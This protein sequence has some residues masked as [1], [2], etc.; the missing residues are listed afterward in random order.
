[1]TKPRLQ[2][3][4]ITIGSPNPRELAAFYQKLLGGIT[5]T[6]EPTDEDD[7]AEAGWAQ[8]ET[9]SE[10]GQIT[11]NFEYEAQWRE[12]LWPSQPGEQH[13]TQ[14]LD[15]EVDDLESAVVWAEQCGATQFRF[16]PQS[17]VRVMR[18]PHGHPFCLFTNEEA[19]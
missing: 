16:Q 10:Y 15:I 8:V 4:S 3:T 17:G 14:H 13:I 19:E 18:D 12:P 9:N 5:S 1:M 7:A 11:L 6:V 2:L